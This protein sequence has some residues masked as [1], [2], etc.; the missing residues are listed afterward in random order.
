MKKVLKVSAIALSV[1]LAAFLV[2]FIFFPGLPTYIKVKKE[3]PSIDC[4]IKNYSGYDVEIPDDYVEAEYDGV[5]LRG[6]SFALNTDTT[7]TVPF[8]ADKKLVVMIIKCENIPVEYGSEYDKYEKEDYEHFFESLKTDIPKDSYESRVFLRNMQ[9]KDC[10]G[11]RGRDLKVFEEYAESKQTVADIETPYYYE[12]DD[13]KG[14]ICDI[15]STSKFHYYYNADFFT[16]NN[17]YIISVLG[18]NSET[19]KRIIASIEITEE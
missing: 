7:G 10:L 12:R 14:F 8:K 19:I 15:G 3:Y 13:I 16:E 17:E 5:K 1:V 18:N 6:P 4:T 2:I 11:L 9:A